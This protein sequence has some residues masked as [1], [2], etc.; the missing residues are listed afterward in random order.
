[1]NN[2]IKFALENYDKNQEKILKMLKDVYYLEFNTTE[3]VKYITFYDKNK[4]KILHSVYQL[5]GIYLEDSNTWKWGWT[6]PGRNKDETY[7]SRKV[8]DYAFNLDNYKEIELR[9]QLINSTIP[10][11]SNM[12]M[13]INI[14]I[15]SYIT[16]I[17]FIFKLPLI[18]IMDNQENNIYE[19][20]KIFTESANRNNNVMIY[21]YILD[22][23]L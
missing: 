10:I 17:P 6:L 9:S 8:L 15:I 3:R 4:K 20:S 1:M 11:L 13:D 16:K 14:S 22:Y 19:Y 18:Q 23:S 21:M 7:L 2:I 12:Q 5:A